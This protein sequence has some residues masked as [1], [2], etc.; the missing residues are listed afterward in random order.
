MNKKSGQAVPSA[1]NYVKE[2]GK[3]ITDYGVKRL[4]TTL[5]DRKSVV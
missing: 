2:N 4:V 1:A 3:G 5:P